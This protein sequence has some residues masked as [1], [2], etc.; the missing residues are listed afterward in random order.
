M[1]GPD[2]GVLRAPAESVDVAV[3]AAGVDG[4]GFLVVDRDL[5]IRDITTDTH[6]VDG[7]EEHDQRL[8]SVFAALDDGVLV[9]DRR[10]RI[11]EVNP[12][13][14]HILGIDLLSMTAND[15]WW[16][17]LAARRADGSLLELFLGVVASGERVRD[18]R[19]EVDRPDGRTVLLTANCLAL[20]DRAGC[21]D[22]LVLSF[23]DVTRKVAE[24][25]RTAD[26]SMRLQEAHDVARLSSWE[27][28]PVSDEVLIVRAMAGSRV[29]AGSTASLDTLFARLPAHDRASMRQALSELAAG[30]RELVIR[31]HAYA[32]PRGPG[33]LETRACAIHDADGR[34]ARVRGTSQEVTERREAEL[35]IARQAALLDEVDVAVVA[36]DLDR[37]I[38]HWNRGA[39]Q[40]YGWSA[41]EAIGRTTD[42]LIAS[43]DAPRDAQMYAEP[44]RTGTWEG[45]LTATRRDGSTF[46]A[47]LHQRFIVGDD[48]VSARV[49][50]VFTDISERV[51]AEHELA[52]ANDYLKAV[53]DSIG[54][55]LFTLDARG[56]VTYVNPAAEQLLGWP[57]ESLHGRIMHDVIHTHHSDGSELPIEHCPIQR[58]RRDGRTVRVEDDV[59]ITREGRRLPVAYTSAPFSTDESVDGCVVVFVDISE[60][61]ARE[62]SLQREADTLEW[63]QRIRDALAEDRLELYAQPIIDLRTG[64]VVQRELLLRMRTPDGQIIAPGEF[65][66]VAEQYGLIGDIDRWVIRRAAQIA[67]DGQPVE[68]NLSAC[69]LADPT[70]IDHIEQALQRQHLDPEQMVFEITETAL[71]TDQ[72]AARTFAKRLHTLGARLALDDFGTG[73]GGLA[74][75]KQISVNYLKIDVEFVRD[76]TTNRSSRRLVEHIVSLA[77]SFEIETIA[78]GVEDEQTLLLVQ[79]LG[80]D[81]AQGYHIGRP[82]RLT[83]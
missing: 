17:K 13:A 44:Q 58:A 28:D 15:E 10:G 82:A 2:L 22:G 24:A 57:A 77:Q 70:I 1:T 41:T 71:I 52:K 80:V 9:V 49:I 18:V 7:R 27:W 55:G 42:E 37:R 8:R 38:T 23:R 6:A 69:S 48:E 54:E 16:T 62:E 33:W 5:R 65:L 50:G 79:Q 68:L 59:F 39:E 30:E 40:L 25:R 20:R 35:E 3:A 81:F 12:A 32:F 21:V 67:A 4:V 75:L 66:P 45:Q 43:V 51:A 14:S 76:L 61:K 78:E 36:S 29:Q 74:Y 34:L 11:L 19:V 31:R 60:R 56:R 64:A 83:D 53:T 47:Y 63:I 26:L 46:P 72:D 73:Y